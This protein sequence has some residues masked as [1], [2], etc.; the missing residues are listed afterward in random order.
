MLIGAAA[1]LVLT[2]GATRLYRMMREPNIG[3]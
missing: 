2:F 1:P 3:E